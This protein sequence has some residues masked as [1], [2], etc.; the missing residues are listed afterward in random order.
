M[1]AGGEATADRGRPS[2]VLALAGGAL[3]GG[4][5]YGGHALLLGLDVVGPQ[6]CD[7]LVGRTASCLEPQP[8][9][10]LALVAGVVVF[11]GLLAL[12]RR[13]KVR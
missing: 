2:P 6:G 7:D 5:V 8:S 4:L 1:T 10:T 11:L 12:L 3:I 9:G 13:R